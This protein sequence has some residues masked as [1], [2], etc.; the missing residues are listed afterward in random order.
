MRQFVWLGMLVGAVVYG[1]MLGHHFHRCTAADLEAKVFGEA[2]EMP[3][4]EGVR[5]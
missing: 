1:F 4:D 3:I 5:A 2:F